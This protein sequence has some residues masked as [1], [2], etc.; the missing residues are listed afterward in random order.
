MTTLDTK[1]KASYFGKERTRA[2]GTSIYTLGYKDGFLDA[3]QEVRGILNSN[4]NNK[5]RMDGIKNL[6]YEHKDKLKEYGY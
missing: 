5:N 4:S 3:L 6:L 2:I 1:A